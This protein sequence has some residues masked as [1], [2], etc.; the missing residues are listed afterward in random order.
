[1]STGDPAPLRI[2]VLEA[3]RISGQ[4]LLQPALDIAGVEV[5]AIAARD[6]SRAR[7]QADA[8]GVARVHDSY[9]A[10]LTDPD[11][12]AV[13][14][15]LPINLHHEWTLAAIESGKHVLCEKPFASNADEAVAMVAA[16]AAAD[17][18]LVEAFHWRYHPLADRL[19]QILDS[20]TLGP[21]HS[22]DAGF[23]MPIEPDDE[24]RQSWE[25]SGGALMDLGCYPVQWVRFAAA[26]EPIVTAATMVQGRPDVD[27]VT[28]IS[29]GFANGIEARVR[30]AMDAETGRASW[31]HVSGAEGFLRVVNPV[32]PHLDHEVVIGTSRGTTSE[33]VQGRST[34][35]HQ[36]EAFV[37]AV[38]DGRPVP[39]GGV[40]AIANMRVIDAAYRVAG[41]EP[42]GLRR[43]AE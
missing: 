4:A 36:L 43:T 28:E 21:I 2:G 20:G 35:H 7:A 33:Q 41:L 6:R 17:R 31:L 29:L 8:F 16:A 26:G 14:I 40:D 42:R 30:T 13:Y 11:V 27:V 19:R 37:G 23:T 38:V 10:L 12:D 25:L 34:Y 24:V 22:I 32:A 3:A 9:S 18:V 15:P 5:V 1:M 39:T